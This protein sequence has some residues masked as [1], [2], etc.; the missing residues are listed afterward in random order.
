MIRSPFA[1]FLAISTDEQERP[2]KMDVPAELKRREDRL[3]KIKVAKAAVE[4]RET[5]HCKQEEYDKKLKAR[6]EKEEKTAGPPVRQEA[7][8]E[9]SERAP[10]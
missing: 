6:T 7:Q 2:E 1:L 5:E 4:A 8:R 9:S 3:E 10:K